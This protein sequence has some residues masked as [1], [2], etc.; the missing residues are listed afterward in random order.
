M[1]YNI[2]MFLKFGSEE[3]IKD[4]YEN[5][6]IYL[7]TVQYFKE[8]EKDTARGDIYEGASRIVNSLPGTLK[9]SESDEEFPY[10]KVHY[11]EH[12]TEMFGNIYSLYC[13]SSHGFPD[14]FKFKIDK[15]ITQFG[16]HALAI[17]DNQ[18][19][20]NR[21]KE[22]LI[23]EGYQFRHSFV[24][25]YDKDKVSKNLTVFEKPLEYEYQ[26]EFRFFVENNEQKPIVLKIGS[27]QKYSKIVDM[28][29]IM[30]MKLI[31]VKN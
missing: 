26:K 30:D 27:L 24:E 3:N 29:E 2:K 19:F 18:Y 17:F 12:Y 10:E 25:Y 31:S 5:G 11:T 16:T 23:N 22:C 7:N 14:P 6:T 20:F 8:L 21:I 9:I 13:I 4:L 1:I 15:R 28:K